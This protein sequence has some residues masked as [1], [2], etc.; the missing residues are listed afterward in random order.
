MAWK[1]NVIVVANVTA[2]SPEL[3]N[4][5]LRKAERGPTA[6]TLVVPATAYG[7]GLRAAA[8]TLEEAL[9]MLREAGLEVEGKV[10]SRNPIVAVDEL[11]DPGR[12]DEIVVSTLPLSSSKWLRAGLPERIG[13]LTGAPITHIVSQPP[14]P[15]VAAG[16]PPQRRPHLLGPLEVLGWGGS[17]QRQSA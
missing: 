14:K 17:H 13:K 10:G 6:F 5:L 8:T 9:A 11:W 4:T 12:Y 16:P 15:A 1:T 2:T 3:L 7:G